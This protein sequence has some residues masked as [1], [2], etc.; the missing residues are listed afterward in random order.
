MS[1]SA[2]FPADPS[3][4]KRID[5]RVRKTNL[6]IALNSN[7]EKLQHARPHELC[8]VTHEAGT[9]LVPRVRILVKLAK[10]SDFLALFYCF[11]WSFL[12]RWSFK[13]AF[14]WS[15][16]IHCKTARQD[17][18]QDHCQDRLC[19]QYQRRNLPTSF[20]GLFPPTFKGKALGTRLRINKNFHF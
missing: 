13:F 19:Y 17:H 16:W 15:F 18:C 11:S 20:P 9:R 7:D 8:H 1:S 2:N 4:D 12:H 14:S 10:S 3:N 5:N 6:F